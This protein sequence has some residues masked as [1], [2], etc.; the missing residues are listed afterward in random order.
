MALSFLTET[1]CWR[2]FVARIKGKGNNMFK[3]II[4]SFFTSLAI[5]FCFTTSP[6]QFPI[7]GQIIDVIDGKTV[8]VAIQTGKVRV[9]LQ[10]IDVPDTGQELHDVVKE[11]LRTL[12]AGKSIVYR[13][14][15]IGNDYTIGQVMVRDLDISQQML[16]DGAAWLMPRETSGQEKS[17]FAVYAS[18]EAAAKK[19]K[20]GVWSIPELKPA[21]Q[22]RAEIKER[23]KAAQDEQYAIGKA[24]RTPVA[25]SRKP[26]SRPNLN[27]SLGNVGALA[28]GYD[29]QTKNG[30]LG[31]SYLDVGELDKALDLEQKTSVDISYFY[32]Q[33][34]GNERKGTYVVTIISTSKKW[35]FLTNNNLILTN[36]IE[37][38]AGSKGKDI[39]IGKAKRTSSV[40]GDDM[41]EK[42]V[43]QIS[44]EAL[45]RIVN[46]DEL[47]LKIGAYLL[48]PTP[49][50]KY[51]LY[52]LLQVS[53]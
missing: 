50:L 30:Y 38:P 25:T 9:E 4:L 3:I 41:R 15:T 36:G 51:V 31:T 18:L 11:H 32:K 29:P 21:W 45:E 7:A 1:I 42:L 47:K 49:G 8:L 22:F 17:E 34:E 24:S 44:R 16:R 53:Q 39:V 12:L 10:Y 40:D 13:P 6:A 48:I 23:E 2:I 26:V 52:N 46:D 14:K 5:L 33:L 28:N 19:D 37:G 43:Y 27:P 20:I 35:R